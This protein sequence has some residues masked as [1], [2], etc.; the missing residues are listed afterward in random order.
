MTIKL[1][2]EAEFLK[3]RLS[4][5]FHNDDFIEFIVALG[6]EKAEKILI[7]G[8]RLEKTDLTYK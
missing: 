3:I 2:E 1:N 4:E 5:T 6:E 7:D 8:T